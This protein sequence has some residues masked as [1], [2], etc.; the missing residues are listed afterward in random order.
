MGDVIHQDSFVESAGS[1]SLDSHTPDVGTGWTFLIDND[2]SLEV[3]SIDDECQIDAGGNGKGCFYT[4]DASYSDADYFCQAKLVDAE[5]GD[6]VHVFGLRVTDANN[7]YFL[8]INA[9][10][11]Q[12][13]KLVAGTPT[14]LAT[15]G[16][17]PASGETVK[18]QSDGTNHTSYIEGTKKL[19]FTDSAIS[20]TGKAGY[21]AGEVVV[22]GDD[23]D[24]QEMD[25]WLVETV[26]SIPSI[27]HSG[28]WEMPVPRPARAIGYY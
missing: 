27:A 7:G 2:A 3:D 16:D 17:N 28:F 19:D 5:S 21:G 11:H 26:A 9:T 4:A 14:Q 1:P 10:Q 15:N 20:A 18:M 8:R 22:S 23:A 13:Y 25:D 12:W 6:D 24:N